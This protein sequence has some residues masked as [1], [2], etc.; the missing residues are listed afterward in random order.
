MIKII[1]SIL[2]SS[3]LLLASNFIYSTNE[4]CVL[5]IENNQCVS[6]EAFILET[7]KSKLINIKLD[8]N[9]SNSISGLLTVSS[10]FTIAS[11]P[12]FSFSLF[13]VINSSDKNLTYSNFTSLDSSLVKGSS[14]QYN[15]KDIFRKR[16]LLLSENLNF[17]KRII[18]NVI[19]NVS[20]RINKCKESVMC[21]GKLNYLI[22][23]KPI[24]SINKPK[25]D[26]ADSNF[27][28]INKN[29]IYKTVLIK[30][31]NEKPGFYTE[32]IDSKNKKDKLVFNSCRNDFFQVKDINFEPNLKL[33]K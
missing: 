24:L 21:E 7:G 20:N 28:K 29:L 23:L 8:S 30:C 15:G 1:S 5:D 11:V 22:P 16:I 13:K 31:F 3:S 9:S 26:S 10:Q 6:P 2:I 4:K 17:D 32:I 12:G 14:F 25:I 18:D 19:P 33:L 27:L